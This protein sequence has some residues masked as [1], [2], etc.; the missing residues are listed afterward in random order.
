MAWGFSQVP[1]KKPV[2]EVKPV[3]LTQPSQKAKM[4]LYKPKNERE[5]LL[6]IAD[7]WQVKGNGNIHQLKKILEAKK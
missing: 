5:R 7:V 6:A 1:P 2:Q 4:V 3:V